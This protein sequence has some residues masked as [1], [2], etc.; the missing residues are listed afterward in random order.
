M[1]STVS[2]FVPHNTLHGRI[3]QSQIP[4]SLV[5]NGNKHNFLHSQWHMSQLHNDQIVE[6]TARNDDDDDDDGDNNEND[7]FKTLL[8][9]AHE[10]DPSFAEIRIPFIDPLGNNVIECKPHFNVQYNDAS[11]MIATPHDHSVVFCYKNDKTGKL[12]VLSDYT[13]GSIDQHKEEMEDSKAFLD[14]IF[15]IASLQLSKM[16]DDQLKLRRTP[17]TLTIEGDLG[18]FTN[19]AWEEQKKEQSPNQRRKNFENLW[20]ETGLLATDEND[21]DEFFESTMKD[22]LGDDYDDDD[23]EDDEEIDAELLEMFHVFDENN[24]D[25]I[26]SFMRD[27]FFKDETTDVSE[28]PEDNA[29]D[30]DAQKRNAY[31]EQL[32]SFQCDGKLISLVKLTQPSIIV[33]REDP[34]VPSRRVLLTPAESNVLIPELE[35]MIREELKESGVFE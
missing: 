10:Q 19:L 17:H 29:D 16:F 4:T 21:V 18:K 13:I 27:I 26:K 12:V 33:G 1:L 14:D 31:A 28:V 22:F 15:K 34:V 30:L 9:L 11:Y 5:R 32:L 2:P 7:S 25:D 6:T 24:E 3:I 8:D 20:M 23:D 35:K